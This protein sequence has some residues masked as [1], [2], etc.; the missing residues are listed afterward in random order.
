MIKSYAPAGIRSDFAKY[1]R[2][3]IK[4]GSRVLIGRTS[5]GNRL[6]IFSGY[7]ALCVPE[8]AYFHIVS[9][10]D[11]VFSQQL[12][13]GMGYEI[14]KKKVHPIR[15]IEIV[16]R[17]ERA[18]NIGDCLPTHYTPYVKLGDRILAL[19]SDPR[20]PIFI[21]ES[22]H[23]CFEKEKWIWVSSGER[24]P[25]MGMGIDHDARAIIC[26][27]LGHIQPTPADL[28]IV[29]ERIEDCL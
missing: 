12:D 2:Q 26:P 19:E 1:L 9:G 13:H 21:P 7:I 6:Y 10:I 16:Y 27:A 3:L 25:L 4:G 29:N 28:A 5:D 20:R 11:K 17:S 15:T 8:S 18:W 24:K 14:V 22:R 23:A